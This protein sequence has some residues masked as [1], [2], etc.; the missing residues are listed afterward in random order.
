MGFSAYRQVG[1]THFE[2]ENASH[3]YTLVNPL[4]GS[5]TLLLDMEGGVVHRW[6]FTDIWPGYGRLLDNGNLLLLG[7]ERALWDELAEGWKDAAPSGGD[8]TKARSELDAR[9]RDIG[10]NASLIREVDWEGNVVWEY[11]NKRIHH[12]FVRL[13]NG[14]HVLAEWIE[15]PSR[16]ELQVVGGLPKDPDNTLPMLGDEIFEIDS[17]GKELWR[18]KLWNLHHPVYDPICPLERRT[19]WTHLNSL[20]VNENGDVLFSC[21]ANSRVGII[22]GKTGQLVWNY[23]Q[24]NTFHQHHATFLP[25]SNVQIF[26]NGMHRY[27]HPRSRVIEVDPTTDEVVWEYRASPEIQFFS[28]HISGAERLPNGNLLICEG[29][30][31]RIFEI[32]RE[33]HVVWEWVNPIMNYVRGEP[34]YYIFRAHR[35]ADTHMAIRGHGL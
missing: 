13:P 27:G 12:D 32:T 35:Y 4:G 14:N 9:V 10:G 19:E 22:D 11:K 23:G 28:A 21:R 2:K 6:E 34:A 29:A 24:P 8:L 31:G 26:D 25:N 5:A 17:N 33:G 7:V 3:G 20:D 18:V 30:P 15:L 1:L 16:V